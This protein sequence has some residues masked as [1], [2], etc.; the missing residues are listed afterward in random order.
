MSGQSPHWIT[1]HYHARCHQC[2]DAIMIGSRAYY[3]PSAARVPS[4]PTRVPSGR[5]L[6]AVCGNGA[7]R[8]A[9][10]ALGAHQHT[11]ARP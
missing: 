2:G 6:C 11:E 3:Y 1:V 10:I 9:A 7:A 5:I 8:S 4:G